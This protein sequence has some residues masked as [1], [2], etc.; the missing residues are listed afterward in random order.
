MSWR[1]LNMSDADEHAESFTCPYC[2]SH[3]TIR[4]KTADHVFVKALGGHVTVAACRDCNS[5]IGSEIE[6]ALQE[7]NTYLNFLKQLRG[8]GQAVRATSMV[9]EGAVTYDMATKELRFKQPVATSRDAA[10]ILFQI[11]GSRGQVRSILTSQGHTQA[12]I[13]NLMGK[14]AT[15]QLGGQLRVSLQHDVLIADRLAAKVALGAGALIGGTG[16]IDSVLAQR[17]RVVLWNEACV[18]VRSDIKSLDAIDNNLQLQMISR[19]ATAIASVKPGNMD[20]Q[21][22]FAPSAQGRTAVFVHIG[23]MPI[24]GSGTLYP[25]R[26]AFTGGLPAILKDAPGQ[27]IVRSLKDEVSRAL[28]EAHTQ[29][30]DDEL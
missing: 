8:G 24:T 22:I 29:Q 1:M 12:Q 17:L 9:D 13:D 2:S 15:E 19:G 30:Y 7:P 21:V 3:M 26:A 10:K 4:H 27:A 18:V 5:K 20:S 28:V 6:G 11:K 14:A 25:G 23:G 16:F